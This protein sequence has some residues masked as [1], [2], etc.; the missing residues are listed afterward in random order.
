VFGAQVAEQ[1][2][3]CHVAGDSSHARPGVI[4]SVEG[5]FASMAEQLQYTYDIE[6][7]LPKAAAAT[8]IISRSTPDREFI[9]VNKRPV[10][11]PALSKL[12]NQAYRQSSSM[13]AISLV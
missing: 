1:L 5:C 12:I 11:F 4:H 7:Y 13:C 10:D 2:T 8:N 6:A 9:F 3:R